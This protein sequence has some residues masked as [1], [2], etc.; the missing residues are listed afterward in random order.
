MPPRYL[1]DT[2]ILIRWLTGSSRLERE[3]AKAIQRAANRREPVAISAI[4]LLEIALLQEEKK[5]GGNLR[6]SSMLD[7]I[8]SSPFFLLLPLTCEIAAD[9]PNLH[10]LRDPFDRA[11]A[12]TARVHRLKL[13]TSDARIAAANLVPT[14]F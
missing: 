2:H 5:I 8:E 4:S 14:L 11:I 7:D 12:A 6:L 3:Q 10:A 9:F 13:I 1:L